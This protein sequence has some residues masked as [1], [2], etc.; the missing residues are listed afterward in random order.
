MSLKAI[1]GFSVLFSEEGGVPGMA[2]MK[3][4]SVVQEGG[5]PWRWE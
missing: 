4:G 1:L 2:D 5:A 3:R